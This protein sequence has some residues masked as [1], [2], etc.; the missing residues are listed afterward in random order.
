MFR[1]IIALAGLLFAVTTIHAQMEAAQKIKLD[2][3]TGV[4]F[5]T[6]VSSLWDVIKDPAGWASFSNGYVQ[7]IT[8]T[9]E[10]ANQRRTFV[11]ADGTE[12]TDVITQY[13]PEYKMIVFKVSGP[14]EPSVKECSVFFVV[15]T[16]EEPGTAE[17]HIGAVIHGSK[18]DKEKMLPKLKKEMSNYL[19]GMSSRF[20]K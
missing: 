7:S 8:P 3:D 16:P 14:L 9:G 20:S 15:R 4:V 5:K 11:F 10:A 6:T 13:Q 1:K 18:T 17:L 2:I 12:R 19:Q